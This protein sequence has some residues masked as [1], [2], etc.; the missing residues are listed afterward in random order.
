MNEFLIKLQAELD[1]VR[2]KENVNKD[3]TRIQSQLDN[4]KIKAE[5]D[6]KVIQTLADEIGKLANKKII[7][8]N[9]GIDNTQIAKEAINAGKQS[10][11]AFVN[12]IEYSSKKINKLLRPF[13]ELKIGTKNIGAVLDE[14]G[15]IDTEKSLKKIK[16][17]YSEFGQVT[18]KN[19]TFD[20]DGDIQT[21]KI[22]I[23]QVN[24]ELKEFREFAMALNGTSFSFPEDIIKGSESIVQHL[25]KSKNIINETA[26]AIN[27]LKIQSRVS[28]ISKLMDNGQGASKYQNQID[29]YVNDFKK[30]GYSVEEAKNRTKSLQDTLDNMKGMSGQQ[31]IDQADKLEQGFKD[32]E[33]SIEAAKLAYDKFE[34]P[35]SD[36]KIANT[37]LSINKFL[38][39]NS[40]I[41]DEA[42]I[43]LDKYVKELTNIG[44]TENR[45]KTINTEFKKTQSAMSIIG[46]LG[47]SCSDQFKEIGRNVTSYMSVASLF[48]YL[49]SQ[50]KNSIIELKEINSILTEISKTSELTEQQL[51]SMGNTSFKAASKYGKTASDYLIGIQE[52]YRTGFKN[53]E[54]MSK[55]SILAQ[56]AGD[57]DSTMSNDYLIATNAAYDLKGNIE[58]LNRVLDGQNFI[59]NNAAVSMRDMAEATSEAA[60]IASQYGVQIDELSALIAMAT[61]KTRESGNETGNALKSLFVNL[62]D[63]T[64]KPIREAFEAVEISMTEIVDGSERLKTPIQ[65]LKELSDAFVSLNE[66]D[67]KR[68]NILS[69]IGGKYHAN[70]LSAIL[71]DWE[72]YEKMLDLYSRGMGSAAKEAEKSAKNWEGSMARLGN[73]WTS[74]INNIAD[75]DAIIAGINGLNGLLSVINE[76][77]SVLKAPGIIGAGAGLFASLKNVGR[78]KMY[79]LIFVVLNSR[80]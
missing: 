40:R 74:T 3:I 31:L 1:E 28:D 66:G 61:S 46:K 5:L 41:T 42:R 32:V 35:A 12:G 48:S 10:G 45:L 69:D 43:K 15:L 6:P 64:S 24:G 37:I 60:S 76:I 26:D 36:S 62:Q 8:S 59:T 38:E 80:L 75:S 79:S 27:E 71:S 63:T 54:Q 20:I 58:A 19:K 57:M 55:L 65:L 7:I 39:S 50:T 33:V 21:F 2:S 44:A 70:T 14:Q 78:D 25:D 49:F 17:L 30:Y 52:M 77:T 53:A 47:K 16:D 72:S 23:E 68:A 18:I 4:L 67:T 11:D 73:T 56:S 51:K 29:K 9:I 34:Q 13:S 22:H